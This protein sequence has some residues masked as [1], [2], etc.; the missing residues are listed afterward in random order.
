MGSVCSIVYVSNKL[1]D[2]YEIWYDS[3]VKGRC[4]KLVIPD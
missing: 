2:L 4:L 1:D 3:Y